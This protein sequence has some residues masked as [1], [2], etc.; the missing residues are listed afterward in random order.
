MVST[1]QIRIPVLR[2]RP[3]RRILAERFPCMVCDP[4]LADD[5][6]RRYRGQSA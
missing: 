1:P 5:P 4:S 3:T 2:A 6:A